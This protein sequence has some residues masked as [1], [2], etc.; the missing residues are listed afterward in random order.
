M[1]KTVL[2]T[3]G[4]R[5]I[6]ASTANVF[7]EAGYNVAI[8]YKSNADSAITLQQALIKNGSNARIFQADISIN[9]EA[10]RLIKDAESYFG[11]IDVLVNN[12]GISFSGPFKSSTIEDQQRIIALNIE[13]V[14]NCTR[15]VLENMLQRG[16]G[17]IVNISSIMGEA[18]GSNEVL[19]STTKAALIGFTKALAKEVSP[20]GIRVNCVAP[21]YI[22]TDMSASHSKQVLEEIAQQTP[23][24]RLG[25]PIDVANIIFYLCS[26]KADF[27]TGQIISPNGGLY[28]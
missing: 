22:F 24:K 7:A 13:G 8:N 28:I 27:I 18:G 11:G 10:E 17:N 21:G 14:L 12:A 3:G 20:A 15:L 5:G 16:C 9:S 1:T 25:K 19:Y 2:I 23:C 26:E 6:G 4:S